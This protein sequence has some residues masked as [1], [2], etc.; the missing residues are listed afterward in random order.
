MQFLILVYHYTGSSQT[1]GIYKIVRI[2]VS[3]YLFMTG[4][5]HTI[6]F[7]QNN[8]Y[9]LRRCAAVLI[10]L[11]LLSCLL[12]YAM[13]TDYLFYYFAPL[14]TFWYMVI[15]LTMR[16]G[17]SRNSSLTFLI[18]KMI[19][20]ASIVA[21][22]IK[23]PDVLETV[24]AI[25]KYTCNIKW[26]VTEWRFR[27]QLDAYIVFVGMLCGVTLTMASSILHEE[28][29]VTVPFAPI[30]RRHWAWIRMATISSGL[31]ALPLCWHFA[32]RFSNKADYN[33]W[34]PYFSWVP[35]LSFV[36]LRN[37]TGRACNYR[38]SLFVWLGRHSLETFTLQFH[39]WLAADTK[40]LLALGLFRPTKGAVD[41]RWADFVLIT[42]LFFWMSWRAAA[43]TAAITSW[44]VG[45]RTIDDVR[46]R[47]TGI[48]LRL[49]PGR[50]V[51]VD[52]RPRA[53]GEA[54][55]LARL[56][57]GVDHRFRHSLTARL[58]LIMSTMWILNW[59]GSRD[60]DALM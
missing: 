45:P 15:Y 47:T 9:S 29:T 5:G 51:N 4:F 35:I 23:V 8:D 26:N 30:I 44:I 19:I 60:I 1:L 16:I 12:P 20:S 3:S 13:G 46:E 21:L 2:L 34:V 37:C 55:V 59:V 32:E 58:V 50:H 10:R 18:A 25:L 52:D 33:R 41:G 56:W 6:F 36:I 31:A 24:F 14:I 43:A 53:V 22:L 27:L 48:E 38:S 42:I 40:G 54:G 7:Y 39:I 57:H 11:N 17:H 28:Q 49:R